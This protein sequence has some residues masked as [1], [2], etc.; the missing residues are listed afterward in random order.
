MTI[1]G[2]PEEQF[3]YV[4]MVIRSGHNYF[5]IKALEKILRYLEIFNYEQMPV[6]SATPCYFILVRALLILIP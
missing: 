5:L 4:V 1:F 2:S 3:G 6:L